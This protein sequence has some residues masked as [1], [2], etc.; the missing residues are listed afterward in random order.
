MRKSPIKW[1]QRLTLTIAVDWEVVKCQFK[2]KQDITFLFNTCF[3][4]CFS[5]SCCFT[6]LA[7]KFDTCTWISNGGLSFNELSRVMRKPDICLS[8]NKCAVTAQLVCAFVFASRTE[9]SLFF[10][11]PKF[12]ASHLL[13]RLYR[14]VCVRP[15]L[16]PRRPVFL[17]CGSFVT[18]PHNMSCLVGKP[19]ICI[20]E[21][22]DADQLRG[23]READQRL[24]FRYS[25]STILLLHKSEISSF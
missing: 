2:Q 12:Q 24:C 21:N 6:E 17:C 23:N 1:R 15:G 9:K 14:P 22:K 13:L 3:V 7:Q 19:T 11:N 10:L 20:G 8:E 25:D 4:S 16:K 18:S 5:L